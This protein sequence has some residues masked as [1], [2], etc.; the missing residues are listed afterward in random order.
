MKGSLDNTPNSVEPLIQIYVIGEHALP[1]APLPL[2]AKVTAIAPFI[3]DA[4]D[5]THRQ[6]VSES[7]FFAH[8]GRPPLAGELGCAIAHATAYREFLNTKAEWAL[9]F[10]DDALIADPASLHERC[11][12][13]MQILTLDESLIVSFC[14]PTYPTGFI[15]RD[16]E[17]TGLVIANAPPAYAVAYLFNRR[18]AAQLT[19]ATDLIHRVADWPVQEPDV[20]FLLDMRCTVGEEN[21]EVRPQSTIDATGTS[22]PAPPKSFDFQVWSFIWWLRNRRAFGGLRAYWYRMLRP[23]IMLRWYPRSKLLS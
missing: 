22:R 17:S 1:L 2:N 12:E 6:R 4:N 13:L 19:T 10:E 8:Y 18:A 3:Y 15:K 9:V 21:P 20:R 7:L 23:R 5:V 16:G 11:T 14:H